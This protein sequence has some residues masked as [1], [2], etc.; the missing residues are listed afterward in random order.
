[1]FNFFETRCSS[2]CFGPFEWL[3]SEKV[4]LSNRHTSIL[5]MK[6]IEV[7]AKK[8]CKQNHYVKAIGKLNN[9]LE[10]GIQRE[11]PTG[12]RDVGLKQTLEAIDCIT[13]T[14]I[15]VPGLDCFNLPIE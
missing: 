10:K 8:Q 9:I 7:E 4:W 2:T 14:S 3:P 13:D 5:N 6:E 15:L 11:C 12:L 1:M